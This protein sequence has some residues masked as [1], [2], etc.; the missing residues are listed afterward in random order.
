MISLN[1]VFQILSDTCRMPVAKIF[2][3]KNYPADYKFGPHHHSDI[4]INYVKKGKCK[5][6]FGDE[7]VEFRK[8]DCMIIFPNIPHYFVVDNAPA[9]LVQLEFNILNEMNPEEYDSINVSPV[10]LAIQN[11]NRQYLKI[12]DDNKLV[13]CIE[14]TVEELNRKEIHYEILSRIKYIELIILIYRYLNDIYKEISNA[15]PVI[16]HAIEYIDKT[17]FQKIEVVDV[18]IACNTSSRNLRFLF[19]KYLSIAP[20]AYIQKMKIQIASSYLRNSTM[21][22]SNIAYMLSFESPEYL[23]KLF[24]KHTGFSPTEYRQNHFRNDM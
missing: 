10:L 11:T 4:E 16:K 2:E 6:I 1:Q 14:K 19:H 9:T 22:I 21:T 24:K 12:H 20:L 3:I 7:T 5:L 23:S 8:N 17:K 13:E 15:N 18:A